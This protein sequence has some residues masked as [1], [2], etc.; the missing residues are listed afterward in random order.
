MEGYDKQLMIE[1][2]GYTATVVMG[3]SA[4]TLA[5]SLILAVDRMRRYE[6]EDDDKVFNAYAAILKIS[7]VTFIL[8]W[9]TLLVVAI[10]DTATK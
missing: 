9:L 7:S 8:S 2:I 4:I 1:T 5:S 3:V 6:D 10:I